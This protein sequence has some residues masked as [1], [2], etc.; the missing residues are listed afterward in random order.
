[1]AISIRKKKKYRLFWGFYLKN[2]AFRRG[3]WMVTL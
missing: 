3:C 2:W 1:V